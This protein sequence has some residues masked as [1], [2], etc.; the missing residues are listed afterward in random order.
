M[1]RRL[2]L[3]RHPAPDI[4][5]GTCYGARDV[6]LGADAA[7]TIERMLSQLREFAGAAIWTSPAL[8][9]LS[10]A[11]RIAAALGGVPCSDARLRELDFGAWEGRLWSELPRPEVDAWLSDPVER[12][13][14]C[15][16]TGASL[17][18][19][20]RAFHEAQAEGAHVVVS[21]GGPL[22]VFAA[23]ARGC[24]IDLFAP[25]V[26][27]GAVEIIVSRDA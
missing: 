6:P 4:A 8:R 20:V 12:A 16:E 21:H 1:G 25:S 15:G 9:C 24:A 19:R 27:F 26:A 2:A 18:A 3:I 13:P 22:K 14:P 11:E 10:T 23:L 7:T 5:P 17:I